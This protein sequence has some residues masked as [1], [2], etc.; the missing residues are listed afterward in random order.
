MQHTR[1]VASDTYT[2]AG[3]APARTGTLR[4]AQGG[5]T[6]GLGRT[7]GAATLLAL[8]AG[9][10]YPDAGGDVDLLVPVRV[11][12][13]D[14][15]PTPDAEIGVRRTGPPAGRG[16]PTHKTD[17]LGRANIRVREPGRYVVHV[18]GAPGLDGNW[19]H[20]GVYTSATHVEVAH[21]SRVEELTLVAPRPGSLRVE[22]DRGALP[23]P[24]DGL[25]WTEI[26]VRRY[27]SD[28]VLSHGHSQARP[29][30]ERA[31]GHENRY[32]F[33]FT[34]L[35]A[36]RYR[37]KTQVSGDCTSSFQDVTVSPAEQAKV[38]LAVGPPAE[39][40]EFRWHGPINERPHGQRFNVNSFAR[41]GP[42]DVVHDVFRDAESSHI[43]RRLAPGRYVL[44]LWDLN[45][46][47]FVEITG[48]RGQAI[49]VE[50]PRDFLA[51][52]GPRKLEVAVA[53]DEIPANDLLVLLAPVR[54][55]P[56]ESGQWFRIQDTQST[57]PHMFEGLEPGSYD[58]LALDGALSLTLG[59]DP[60]PLVRRMDLRERDGSAR[61]DL[62]GPRPK[63]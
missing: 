46:A 44:I 40:V 23:A 9:P 47:M 19:L 39:P 59:L 13:P 21:E 42:L 43:T 14:G 60:N 30:H 7:L 50:P 22:L 63:R 28:H 6:Q 16:V 11:I 29:R 5:W 36:G 33:T 53:I 27:F 32:I 18:V 34:G 55:R 62:L 2:L 54:E 31:E 3:R 4:A 49:D 48:V 1:D 12:Y 38:A 24:R 35:P 52:R 15:A 37:V 58:V 26:S 51:P 57:S 41:P 25:G 8:A 56:L 61:F 45:L 10:G 17:A 20:R